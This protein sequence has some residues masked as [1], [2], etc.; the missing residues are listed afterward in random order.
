VAGVEVL[1]ELDSVVGVLAAVVGV[2]AEELVEFELPQPVSM[3]SPTARVR[4]ETIGMERVF[5]APA[6]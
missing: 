2:E 1:A 3:S 5:A 6:A 4:I